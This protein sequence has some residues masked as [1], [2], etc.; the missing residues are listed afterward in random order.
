M[1]RA[2]ATLLSA[3][4]ILTGIEA[5]THDGLPTNPSTRLAPLDSGSGSGGSSNLTI[6]KAGTGTGTVTSSP[7]GINCGSSC[8][9]SFTNGTTV[10]LTATPAAGSVFAGWSGGGCSGTGTCT[11]QISSNTTI[12]A[13]FNTAPPPPPPTGT[14][15]LTVNKV[16]SGSVAGFVTSSPAGID[17]NATCTATFPANTSINLFASTTTGSFTGWT[18]GPC[19]GSTNPS[20]TFTLAANTTVTANWG[21]TPLGFLESTLP[22]GNVG[23]DYNVSINTTGGQGGPH[24]FSLAAGALPDGLQMDQFFGVQ[25]TLI[26]GRPTRQQVSTFTVRVQDQAGNTATRTFTITI[27][28]PVTLAITLPGPVA[29]SGTRGQ[30][31]FQNLFASGGRTPYTWSITGGALPPGL[32]VIRASNG[33]RIEGTP[34]SRGTFTFALTVRDQDGQQATQQ[35]SITI[36]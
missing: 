15:T 23:A 14:F 25:S 6:S 19:S 5:C 22:D 17:C 3:V 2:L 21:S 8:Q 9:R 7:S 18:G 16:T 10:T 20:C 36:N 1:F 31:Y 27:Q 30:F 34:T 13:T 26:H 28:A 11:R 33:N 29:K 12:T 4:V 32:R 35:T 24:L